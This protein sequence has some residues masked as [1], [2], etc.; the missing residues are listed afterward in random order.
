M[1][2][3]TKR[4]I[5][6]TEEQERYLARCFG[7]TRWYWNYLVDCDRNNVK[8]KRYAE[9]KRSG[10][11]WL[12][13]A[14]A[15]SLSSVDLNYK[16]ALAN[17]KSGMNKP[18]FHSKHDRQS[19]TVCCQGVNSLR[20]KKTYCPKLKS[21]IKIMGDVDSNGTLKSVTYS[22][23]SNGKYYA[24]FLFDVGRVEPLPK[25]SK[26]I[27]ID[28]G[29]ETFATTSDGEKIKSPDLS[30]KEAK[31]TKEQRVLS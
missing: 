13:E 17:S 30:K 22:L 18:K 1:F 31:I 27:G 24:S 15:I 21:G 3:S 26:M 25:T 19:F 9:L 20:G 7:H 4:E 28:V 12:A 5:R 23:E 8:H 16:T 6:P 2:I 14:P 11:A 10:Y 29:I